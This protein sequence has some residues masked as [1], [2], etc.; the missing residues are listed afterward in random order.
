MRTPGSKTAKSVTVRVVLLL[1]LGLAGC[2][3]GGGQTT[4]TGQTPGTSGPPATAGPAR[5][6]CTLVTAAELATVVGT[7][8]KRTVTVTLTESSEELQ[9]LR[10]EWTY[11]NKEDLTDTA[12]I[13]VTA[14]RGRQFYTPDTQPEGFRPV[15]GIGDAAHVSAALFMFRRGDDVLRIHVSGDAANDRIEPAI[16]R[17]LAT[18]LS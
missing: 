17:L 15:S 8:K 10:C 14:W 13:L 16:A 4:G 6:P 7:V 3:T 5:N 11:P 18:K 2:G 12:T 1:T 9:G